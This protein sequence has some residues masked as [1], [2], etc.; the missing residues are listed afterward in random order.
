M[1]PEYTQTFMILEAES[2]EMAKARFDT[3]PQV[4]AGLIVAAIISAVLGLGMLRR[5]SVAQ[6]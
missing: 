2:I 4:K 5:F 3:Y 6:D 1:D